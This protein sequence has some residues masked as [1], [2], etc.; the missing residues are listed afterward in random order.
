MSELT[1]ALV[2]HSKPYRKYATRRLKNA[3]TVFFE[4]VAL[5]LGDAVVMPSLD[6]VQRAKE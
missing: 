4:E 3:L 2:R 5:S 1:A 6:L